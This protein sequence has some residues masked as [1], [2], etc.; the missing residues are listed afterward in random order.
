MV[1]MGFKLLKPTMD[2]STNLNLWWNLWN[3]GLS[4]RLHRAQQVGQRVSA[5]S[6]ASFFRQW[7]KEF[8]QQTS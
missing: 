6:P 5:V 2:V 1:K 8:Y 4:S 7:V 3:P